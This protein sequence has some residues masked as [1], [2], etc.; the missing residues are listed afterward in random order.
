MSANGQIR[1]LEKKLAAAQQLA[2]LVGE[3]RIP[4]PGLHFYDTAT[5][6]PNGL[7]EV[8]DGDGRPWPRRFWDGLAWHEITPWVPV[9]VRFRFALNEALE[10]AETLAVGEG[11]AHQA[12]S[13]VRQQQEA[14]KAETEA[15]TGV[16]AP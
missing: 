1:D 15:G 2:T 3:Y 13:Q 16:M 4:I 14:A 9:D 6:G 7:W 5:L 8:T 10:T 11:A 12:W